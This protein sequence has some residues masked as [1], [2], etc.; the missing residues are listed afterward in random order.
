MMV[1]QHFHFCKR[2]RSVNRAK[3]DDARSK[4]PIAAG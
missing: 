4:A 2:K 3:L 1:K